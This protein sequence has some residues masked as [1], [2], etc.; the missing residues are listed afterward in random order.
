VGSRKDTLTTY[1]DAAGTIGGEESRSDVLGRAM[2]ED[3]TLRTDEDEVR[4]AALESDIEGTRMEM[5]GTIE[6]IGEKLR[7]ENV[8]EQAK[9]NVRD[10]TIGRVEGMMDRANE[11]VRQATG[12]APANGGGIVGAIRGNPLPAALAAVGIGWLWLKR[13]DGASRTYR[14]GAY[15]RYGYGPG[16]DAYV[17]RYDGSTRAPGAADQLG[18]RAGEL[19]QGVRE[20]AGNVADQV[21]QT[22]GQVGEQVSSVASEVPY[23][24][25]ET[26]RTAQ[27][28]LGD[29]LQTNP[30]AAGAVV[31]AGGAIAGLMLPTTQRERE[32]MGETRDRLVEQAGQA[33]EKTAQRVQEAAQEIQPQGA[34][35]NGQHA[36]ATPMA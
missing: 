5:T 26:A 2:D 19:A 36:T 13:N 28:R 10:A 22:A 15:E 12:I 8:L 34:V 23:R 32:L 18:E 9:E 30:L 7:P 33:V 6:A 14:Q 17:A 21:G 1:D 29:I 11:S 31:L 16:T 20:T 24:V 27:Q 25:Q 35:S 3:L 4:V